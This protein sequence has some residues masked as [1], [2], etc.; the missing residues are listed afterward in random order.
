MSR[1]SVG[2]DPGTTGAIAL[3]TEDGAV[4][5]WDTPAPKLKVGKKERHVYDVPAMITILKNLPTGAIVTIEELHAMP[6]N[7]GLGNFASGFGYGLWMMA[8]SLLAI[9]HQTVQPAKWKKALGMKKPEGETKDSDKKSVDRMFAC[10]LFPTAVDRMNLVKH[11][12][13]AD[14]LLIAEYGRRLAG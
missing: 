2:I 1:A 7:G 8:L 3:I 10:Q 4:Q 9:P 14:S 12:G 11:H 5:F 6:K 13:R